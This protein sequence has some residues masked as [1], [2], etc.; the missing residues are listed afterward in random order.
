MSQNTATFTA[1]SA[2]TSS[3]R[4]AVILTGYLTEY[5]LLHFQNVLSLHSYILHQY[6]FHV[7]GVFVA[8]KTGSGLDDCI[9][10]QFY[11]NYNQL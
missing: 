1:A 10:W 9:Y 2:R 5:T 4:I 7:F 6:T 3:L 8:N 11:Y